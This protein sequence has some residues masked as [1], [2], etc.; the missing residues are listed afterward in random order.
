MLS[1]V[2]ASRFAGCTGCST[3]KSCTWSL[4]QAQHSHAVQTKQCNLEAGGIL[5]SAARILRR[6]LQLTDTHRRCSASAPLAGLAVVLRGCELRA[7]LG[8][9][10]C[11][12]VAGRF[13]LVHLLLQ[14]LV[15]GGQRQHLYSAPGS[16]LSAHNWTLGSLTKLTCGGEEGGRSGNAFPTRPKRISDVVGESWCAMMVP[17]S[18]QACGSSVKQVL[19]QYSIDM[20]DSWL[21]TD[22]PRAKGSFTWA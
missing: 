13:R 11:G 9:L 6:F 10:P 21:N 5:R 8:Q 16:Q 1:D 20:T 3:E 15:V 17:H 22:V 12:G 2:L 19:N 14:P 7:C 4:H 18:E